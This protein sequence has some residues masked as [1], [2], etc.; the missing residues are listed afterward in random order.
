MA[1]EA[2]STGEYCLHRQQEQQLLLSM[3]MALGVYGRTCMQ[4]YVLA[5]PYSLLLSYPYTVVIH[6]YIILILSHPYV[7]L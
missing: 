3:K 2:I 6:T 4:K 7:I 1:Q 5:Y